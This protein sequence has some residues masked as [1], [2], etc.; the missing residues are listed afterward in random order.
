M[1]HSIALCLLIPG[2]LAA[3]DDVPEASGF[4][5]PTPLV[6]G[7]DNPASPAPYPFIPGRL[8][9]QTPPTFPSG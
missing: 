4:S 5:V 8:P 3:Q 6:A 7:T 2:V 1:K 9:H